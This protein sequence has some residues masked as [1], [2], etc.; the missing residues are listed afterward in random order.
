MI[1]TVL[2]GVVVL[3]IGAL[4]RSADSRA[5]DPRAHA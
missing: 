3:D 2:I 5:L 4:L 1:L